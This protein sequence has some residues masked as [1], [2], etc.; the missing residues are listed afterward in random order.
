MAN[1]QFKHYRYSNPVKEFKIHKECQAFL[2]EIETMV[3]NMPRPHRKEESIGYRAINLAM[4]ILWGSD[5]ANRFPLGSKKRF[6][7]QI[8]AIK[9]IN[10]LFSLYGAMEMVGLI[11]EK[12]NGE[13]TRKTDNL[14]IAFE[15][16]MSSD[17]EQIKKKGIKDEAENLRNQLYCWK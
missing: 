11:T 5:E 10:K 12:K 3:A 16:W 1:R 9:L 4:K 2:G 6:K 15:Y 14:R 8:K 17:L 13:I 7:K